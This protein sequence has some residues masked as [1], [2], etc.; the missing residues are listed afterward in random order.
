MEA[1]VRLGYTAAACTD[2][3][4]KWNACFVKNVEAIK[5]ADIRFYKAEAKDKLK[6][7]RKHI[8][9]P[10]PATEEE[11]Q[12]FIQ[13]LAKTGANCIGLRVF[14]E[15][16]NS[17]VGLAPEPPVNKLP[18]SFRDLYTHGNEKVDGAHLLQMCKSV[19]ENLNVT[20]SQI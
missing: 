6:N 13:S 12:H 1:A 4:C 7:S 2:L 19:H 16:S 18:L 5:I 20:L 11:Q 3:S 15:H 9:K 14:K 17:F 10:D 8:R